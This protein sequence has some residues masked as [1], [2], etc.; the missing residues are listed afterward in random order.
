MTL[1][2][3]A[4][5]ATIFFEGAV[6]LPW[7]FGCILNWVISVEPGCPPRRTPSGAVEPGQSPAP[8]GSSGLFC[9]TVIRR[10]WFRGCGPCVG[11]QPVPLFRLPVLFL[12]H[13]RALSLFL[14]YL[15][16]GPLHNLPLRDLGYV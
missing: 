9:T 8:S 12:V 16:V 6:A 1:Y 3:R 13:S 7:F 4:N 2:G 5:G 14:R 10:S 15:H 11:S